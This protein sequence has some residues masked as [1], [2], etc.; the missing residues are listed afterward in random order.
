MKLYELP[1]G[2]TWIKILPQTGDP[3]TSPGTPE[4]VEEGEVV[5]FHE[6]VA[7]EGLC[8]NQ[9][10]EPVRLISWCDVEVVEPPTLD[11]AE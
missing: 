1:D 4:M 5:L 2:G 8:E 3:V 6:I 9:H 7:R 10:G 11:A